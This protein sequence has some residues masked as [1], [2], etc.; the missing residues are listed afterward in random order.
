MSQMRRRIEKYRKA[1]PSHQDYSIGCIVIGAPFFFAPEEWIP[2]P[3]DWSPKIV[4]GKSY[5]L[6]RSPGRELWDAVQVRPAAREARRPADRAAKHVAEMPVQRKY[7]DPIEVLPRLG[8]GLFRVLVTDAYERRCAM[9][10]ERT[11]PVFQ[12]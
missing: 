7:G 8:Q 4:S 5:D 10:G 9:T 6:L 11:L 1:P 2:I 12:R 3:G